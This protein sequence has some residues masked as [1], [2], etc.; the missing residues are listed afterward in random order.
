MK[1]GPE[2]EVKFV[3]YESMKRKLKIKPIYECRCN[4]RLQSEVQCRGRGR[5]D[6]RESGFGS[7]IS[8]VLQGATEGRQRLQGIFTTTG[9]NLFYNS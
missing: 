1:K 9:R 3:Y 8:I 7:N 4:D 2:Y 5:G 6:A